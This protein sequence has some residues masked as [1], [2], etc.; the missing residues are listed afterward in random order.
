MRA[1]AL[2]AERLAG[3]GWTDP[4]AGTSTSA[5]T[6][7][8]SWRSTRVRRRRSSSSRCAGGR[9]AISAWPEETVDHRKRTRDPSG[10]VRRCSSG[11]TP[12]P[13]LPLRFDLVV[14]EPTRGRVA[15]LHRHADRTTRWPSIG[16]AP[17]PCATLRRGPGPCPTARATDT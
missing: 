15:R 14:V 7:S 13:H 6:S 16:T 12:V 10:R 8:T 2:V 5:A 9:G 3:A 11:R 17:G 4:G 1:E